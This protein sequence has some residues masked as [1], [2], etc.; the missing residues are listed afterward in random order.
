MSSRREISVGID[1][2]SFA[3][4]DNNCVTMRELKAYAEKNFTG[5]ENCGDVMCFVESLPGDPDI[6]KCRQFLKWLKERANRGTKPTIPIRELLARIEGCFDGPPEVSEVSESEQP[7][8]LLSS[9]FQ[10]QVTFLH[11]L[12]VARE[13]VAGVCPECK[14]T[15]EIQL[16]TSTEPCPRCQG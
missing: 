4:D 3:H 5:E 12:Q 2:I 15:G 16:F 14:G 9:K 6:D 7:E 13:A 11:K 8:K 1:S 10:Q